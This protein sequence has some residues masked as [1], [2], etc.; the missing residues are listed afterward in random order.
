[1]WVIGLKGGVGS[2]KSRIMEFLHEEYEAR[3][4]L[5]DEVAHQL[6][7]PGMPGFDRVI[8]T[9]GS[10]CLRPDGEIDRSVLAEKIFGDSK[11]LQKMNAMIHPLVWEKIRQE[12]RQADEKFVVVE[13]ALVDEKEETMYDEIWYVFASRETRISRLM[14]SRGYSKE[15][16]DSI[17]SS[18]LSEEAY[19]SLASQVFVNDGDWEET[20]RQIKEIV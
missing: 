11:A 8:E 19:R 5:A 3:I 13:A 2:G 4:I 18:Q 12:I 10:G 20:K 17:M 16:C 7:E 1:M 14:E 6:M 15:K 9:F